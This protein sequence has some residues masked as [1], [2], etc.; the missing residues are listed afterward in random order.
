MLFYLFISHKSELNV[1][2][3]NRTVFLKGRFSADEIGLMSSPKDITT[4][5][6]NREFC[7]LAAFGVD[8]GIC[9]NH[10]VNVSDSRI[11][12]NLVV[13]VMRSSKTERVRQIKWIG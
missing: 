6:S 1:I 7:S 9:L 13:L 10:K 2:Y 12:D 4:A 5:G 8:G 3:E 11:T